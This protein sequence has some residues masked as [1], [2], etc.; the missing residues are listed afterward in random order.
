MLGHVNE[1]HVVPELQFL[2]RFYRLMVAAE[3]MRI[4]AVSPPARAWLIGFVCSPRAI[5]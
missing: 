2:E 1:D 4:K 5:S 3:A